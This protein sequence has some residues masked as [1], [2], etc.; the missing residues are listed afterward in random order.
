MRKVRGSWDKL[1]LDPTPTKI[2]ICEMTMRDYSRAFELWS[3]SEGMGLSS[4]DSRRAIRAYLRRNPGLSLIAR[5]GT[6]VIATVLCAHDGRRGFLHHLA[7]ARSYRRRGLGAK[8]VSACLARLA[9][10]GIEKCHIFLH[11]DN[12]YGRRFWSRRGWI[13]REDLVVMSSDTEA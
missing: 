4:A 6:E 11:A 10:A 8:L 13:A 5:C 12:T 9:A 2:A 1:S 7:V 3:R